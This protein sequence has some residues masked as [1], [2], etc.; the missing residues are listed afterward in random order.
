[1]AARRLMVVYADDDDLVR[2]ALT[3]LL[4]EEKIDV[5]ACNGG[6]EAIELCRQLN[7]DAVLLD[8]NMPDPDG[9]E[10]ARRLRRNPGGEALRLIA[11]TG[12]GTWDLRQK[13]MDAGFDDFLT[14]PVPA[15]VL[16]RTLHA[17]ITL[18]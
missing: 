13:A 12:R 17:G 14:K 11:L 9:L 18:K 16:I 8:L 3:R 4:I 5:R 15:A 6:A 10:T 7:P 2:E 1:M